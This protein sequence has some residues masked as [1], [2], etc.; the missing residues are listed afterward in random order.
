MASIWGP[1]MHSHDLDTDPYFQAVLKREI[2]KLRD[3]YLDFLSK[4]LSVEMKQGAG[5]TKKIPLVIPP[6]GFRPQSKEVPPLWM[7]LEPIGKA[8]AFGAFFCTGIGL[9]DSGVN[10]Q[11][12]RDIRSMQ[13]LEI[14]QNVYVTLPTF[15]SAKMR[16]IK[17]FVVKIV[18]PQA[19]TPDNLV[20]N[21]GAIRTQCKDYIANMCAGPCNSNKCGQSAP[22]GVACNYFCEE[23]HA[24]QIST[25]R[26]EFSMALIADKLQAPDPSLINQFD[27]SVR[28]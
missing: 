11:N 3:E 13:N 27:P 12:I 17:T 23:E 10:M 15:S 26:K 9:N 28:Y 20:L 22:L 1:K 16:T 19:N 4:Y 6:I 8:I 21:L 7:L 18:R 25:C 2:E 24:D 14:T 5:A